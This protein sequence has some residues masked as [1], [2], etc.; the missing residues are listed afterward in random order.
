MPFGNVCG[1]F[2]W[3]IDVG[4]LRLLCVVPLWVD[5]PGLCKKET[6]Y[7]TENKQ[8]WF[9]PLLLLDFL[10]W[11]LSINDQDVFLHQVAFGHHVYQSNRK[12]QGHCCNLTYWNLKQ[13]LYCFIN[14]SFLIIGWNDWWL[15]SKVHKVISE[16]CILLSK[17]SYSRHFNSQ[18]S[19]LFSVEQPM[20][21]SY[22]P[23]NIFM[24]SV[25]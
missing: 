24:S 25:R 15:I 5:G 8:P 23:R 21:F 3:L 20:C 11:F 13:Q 12:Q 6:E 22:W 17:K 18:N 7:D 10:S 4:G 2:S 16:N 1:E 9:P 14:I 19:I